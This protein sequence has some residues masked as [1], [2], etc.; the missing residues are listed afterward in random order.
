MQLGGSPSVVF[1]SFIIIS[2]YD[3][4][5]L[6]VPPAVV[7]IAEEGGE[8]DVDVVGVVVEDVVISG[9]RRPFFI[10]LLDSKTDYI[11]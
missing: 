4:E 2:L 6:V 5:V 3:D 9:F 10:V 7:V 1:S 8:I 11:I